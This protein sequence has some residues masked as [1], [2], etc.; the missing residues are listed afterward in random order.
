MLLRPVL[1]HFAFESSRLQ[2]ARL[3]LRLLVKV[4]SIPLPPVLS[5]PISV[6]ATPSSHFGL[7]HTCP[8][9]HLA[10]PFL[11]FTKSWIYAVVRLI[12]SLFKP[13]FTL[14]NYWH[15]V[16]PRT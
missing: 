1:T 12:T 7:I 6:S 8:P 14:L 9:T 4:V 2:D 15:A 5:H 11:V 16:G 10:V 3:A 13:R